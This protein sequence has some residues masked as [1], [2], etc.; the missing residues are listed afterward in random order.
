MLRCGNSPELACDAMA[1]SA[2]ERVG[3]TIIPPGEPCRNGYIESFNSR[4]RDECLN[5]NSFWSLPQ[6]R[7][8]ITDWKDDYNHRRRHNSLGYQ[9][10]AVYGAARPAPTDE[11]LSQRV[12]Q[13]LG[14]RHPPSASPWGRRARAPH[15][16]R[17]R[18]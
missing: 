11:Q 3:L 9:A 6:A 1:D 12:D 8:V 10:P 4:V 15:L 17:R 5:I 13:F 7:V 18:R 2:G 14:S 16:E